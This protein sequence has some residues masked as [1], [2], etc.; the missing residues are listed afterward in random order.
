MRAGT[1]HALMRM[2]TAGVD[3]ESRAGIVLKVNVDPRLSPNART[4]PANPAVA[5]AFLEVSSA[6]VLVVNV[7][8]EDVMDKA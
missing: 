4:R 8:A 2:T 7:R 6:Q 1:A 3:A 5:Q